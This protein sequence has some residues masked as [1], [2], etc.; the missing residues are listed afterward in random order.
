MNAPVQTDA[1]RRTRGARQ[2]IIAACDAPVV[3]QPAAEGILD[4]RSGLVEA[5]VE[6]ERL[7]SAT[8]VRNDRLCRK[9]SAAPVGVCGYP[10]P[11]SISG[12]K[13][14]TAKALGTW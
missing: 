12:V 4:D 2:S 13:R 8:P 5:L 1:I 7:F 10:P 14:K 11:R 9:K 6:A 3:L